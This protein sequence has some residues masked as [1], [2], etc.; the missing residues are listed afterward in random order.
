MKQTVCSIHDDLDQNYSHFSKHSTVKKTMQ[1][2]SSISV[3]C[4]EIEITTSEI[5][6]LLPGVTMVLVI[7][8]SFWIT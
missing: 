5:F 7:I 2:A 1:I 6:S 3:Y 4:K 8:D